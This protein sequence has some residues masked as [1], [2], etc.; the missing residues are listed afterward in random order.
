MVRAPRSTREHG[1]HLFKDSITSSNSA[2]VETEP[3]IWSFEGN[4]LDPNHRG[5]YKYFGGGDSRVGLGSGNRFL[6]EVVLLSSVVWEAGFMD[7]GQMLLVTRDL[8]PLLLLS[9]SLSLQSCPHRMNNCWFLPPVPPVWGE[10]TIMWHKEYLH[11]CLPIENIT[12]YLCVYVCVRAHTLA[13]VCVYSIHTIYIHT[14]I[15]SIHTK[16]IEV[17]GQ[18]VGV[19]PSFYHVGP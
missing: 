18:P 1:I 16:Y 11:I 13:K 7:K 4:I 14:Y 6:L 17:R 19:C 12:F 8:Q 9:C 5:P 15:H 3:L 10:P 2:N